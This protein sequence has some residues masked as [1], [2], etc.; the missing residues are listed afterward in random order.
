MKALS[1][2]IC[3]LL[4]GVG[5]GSRAYAGA[6][7]CANLIYGGTHTSRCFSDEFLS[8]VQKETTIS[9]ER[10]FKTVKLASDELFRYPFTILTGEKDFHFTP[11]ERKNLKR[12]LESGGFLLVSAGCSNQEFDKAFRR[13]LKSVFEDKALERLP[14][15]HTIYRTVFQVAGLQT[16]GHGY[17]AQEKIALEGLNLGG[18]TVVIYSKHGL[19]DTA[20]TEGCCCCGGSEIT[21]ALEVNVNIFVYAL[22]Y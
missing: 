13:E 17:G 21:N 16:K 15:T 19:N 3:L 4:A 2:W 11:D 8:A 12:Y 6:I 5:L 18:K 9:T 22:L 10:R 20:H 1:L 7:Q 14:D